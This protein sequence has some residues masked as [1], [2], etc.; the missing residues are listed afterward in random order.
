MQSA[1]AHILEFGKLI[2]IIIF[3]DIEVKLIFEKYYE[4]YNTR[5]MV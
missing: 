2:L 4:Y 5:N 1:S 3:N